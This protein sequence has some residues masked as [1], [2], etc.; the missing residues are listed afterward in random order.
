MNSYQKEIVVDAQEQ[1]RM[2]V[3]VCLENK[4]IL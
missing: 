1:E 3:E 2:K 4:V